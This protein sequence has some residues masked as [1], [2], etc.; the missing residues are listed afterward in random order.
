MSEKD[1]N[2]SNLDGLDELI[3]DWDTS[4]LE[5]ESYELDLLYATQSDTPLTH[6]DIKHRMGRGLTNLELWN[7]CD[8]FFRHWAALFR[9]KNSPEANMLLQCLIDVN[10]ASQKNTLQL[11]SSPADESTREIFAAHTAEYS[12]KY[13]EAL[14]IWPKLYS[15]VV[16]VTDGKQSDEIVD[17]LIDKLIRVRGPWQWDAVQNVLPDPI[18]VDKKDKATHLAERGKYGYSEWDVASFEA[19]IHWVLMN[20]VLFYGSDKA[21]G[22]PGWVKDFDDWVNRLRLFLEGLI[23]GTYRKKMSS[24]ENSRYQ[25]SVG[26]MLEIVPDLWD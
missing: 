25:A 16:T 5:D 13:E 20:A 9:S 24:D 8:V 14:N 11:P 10:E 17:A 7:S 19:Y 2:S 21:M 4:E 1:Q 23:Y 26:L 18:V 3:T 6:D 12:V 15:A 22:F